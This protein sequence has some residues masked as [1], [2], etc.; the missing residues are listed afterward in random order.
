MTIPA[1]AGNRTNKSGVTSDSLLALGRVFDATLL[2]LCRRGGGPRLAR[3]TIHD[4]VDT[5]RNELKPVAYH[6]A[7][8]IMN[9]SESLANYPRRLRQCGNQE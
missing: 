5:A 1:V 8:D 9:V 3:G 7:S 2:L 4:S 6:P